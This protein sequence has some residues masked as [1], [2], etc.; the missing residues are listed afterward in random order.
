MQKTSLLMVLSLAVAL[1]GCASTEQRPAASNNRQTL[2]HAIEGTK[3]TNLMR[4]LQNL[5]QEIWLTEPEKDS[6]RRE[7]LSH[8]IEV[9]DGTENIV[10][11]ILAVKPE[12]NLDAER[13]QLVHSL[14]NRLSDEA[15]T[16]RY[17]TQVFKFDDIPATLK[18]MNT[19]CSAC[20]TV[21]NVS[22]E[23]AS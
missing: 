1:A 5:P 16:L 2:L 7:A 23:P 19:T 10:D 9:A 15:K 14:T 11:C 6:Q 17:Q 20:H 3:L 21:F 8:V 22:I 12:K 13:Q 18:T 4:R